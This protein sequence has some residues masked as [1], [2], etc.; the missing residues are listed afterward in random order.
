MFCI[1][2]HSQLLQ[3]QQ[4]HDDLAAG[5]A[6]ASSPTTTAKT[7]PH[8]RR[9][10]DDDVGVEEEGWSCHGVRRSKAGTMM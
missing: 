4:Q 8:G 6:S 1:A 3:K 10:A 7:S 5:T 2:V 9:P